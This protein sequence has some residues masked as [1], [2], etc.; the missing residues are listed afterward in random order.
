MCCFARELIRLPAGSAANREKA[1]SLVAERLRRGD[2]E[3]VVVASLSGH[4][5]VLVAKAVEGLP[6]R[7]VCVADTPEWMRDGRPYPTLDLRH[8]AELEARGVPILRN[9]R[10]SSEGAPRF[11]G[12][13]SRDV[14]LSAV[15]AALFWE[16]IVAVGGEG[17]KTAVKSVVLATDHGLLRRGER[18][19]SFGGAGGREAA[20]VMSALGHADLLS[21]APGT[22]LRVEEILCLPTMKEASQGS[23]GLSD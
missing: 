21:G 8:Q 16:G 15:E 19:V 23:N 2:V 3:A 17:L 18:V 13:T 6:C 4:T 7:V 14:P 5:A 1:V 11:D 22:R 10:S 12:N 9:Y 20:V